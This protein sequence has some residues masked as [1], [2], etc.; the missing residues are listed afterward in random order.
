MPEENFLLGHGE[1][2]TEEITGSRGGG[3]KQPPYTFQEAK[4]RLS[5]MLQQ[6]VSHLYEL[7]DDAFPGGS[8]VLALTLNPEYIAKSYFP[9]TLLQ[10]VGID[11]VGSRPKR[12]I[13]EKRSRNRAPEETLTTELFA[14]G[15]RSLFRSWN[16]DL[17]NWSDQDYSAKELVSVEQIAAP[18]TRAKIKGSLPENGVIPMEIVLH[19]SEDEGESYMLEAFGRFLEA[20]AIGHDFGR[21]FY[22][23]GLCF[24]SMS[25]PSEHAE[26]IAAF[27]T[28]RALRKLPELRAFRPPMR[29]AG[30][31]C[32]LPALP[33]ENPVSSEVRVA[34]F[35][36]GIPDGHPITSW[37]NPCECGALK[38]PTSEFHEHGVAVTSA[39][40]FGHISPNKSI[41]RP[42]APIDHYRV[43]DGNPN[44]VFFELYEVLERI[45]GVLTSCD[46]DFV[47]L[48]VGPELPIDDD[49]VH[50]WT[51]VID[52]L[53]SRNST[54]A[55]IAVGNGGESDSAACLDRIQVPSDCVNALAVGACDSMENDW[56]RAPYSSVG[57]GR[58][59][60]IIKPDLVAFGGRVDQP[61]VVMNHEIAPNLVGLFGTSFAAPSIVRIAS[62]V[63]AHF[64]PI[65]NHLAIRALLIHT[66]EK[67]GLDLQE[68]GW[69]RC[70][71]ELSEI[72]LCAD[73]EIRV[74]YQGAIS[75]AKYIR[76]SIPMPPNSIKGTVTL[77][78]TFCYKSETDPHHP[79]N[80]TRAGLEV[81]FRPHSEKFKNENQFHP[82]SR[83]FFGF[84]PSG[85]NEVQLRRDA[86]K[87]ENCLSAS[88]RFRGTSLNNPVFDIHFNSRQEGRNNSSNMS[89]P[90]ALIVSV[91][92]P[93]MDDF[94]DQVV[95]K[96]ATI[97][98]PLQPVL[99]IP[100][101]I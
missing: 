86:F 100:L 28:V 64:G 80:Y 11:V 44:Q 20:R 71:Q 3:P 50:A 98:E 70:A 69:G 34:V 35:D 59:P 49:E 72:V 27:S 77:E 92:A 38:P 56:K 91:R 21:R 31:S 83:S 40:L 97:L 45:A 60:G 95:R 13:P 32:P 79:S 90:Y 85:A 14:R 75:P 24:L 26:E 94:Y 87:W 76:A 6:A 58:S 9:T 29:S 42:Y 25:V 52:Q 101:Q 37:A 18:A 55:A 78:A 10:K 17:P 23:N 19:A 73:D 54:L 93:K 15:H 7:P 5:P 16:A 43:I 99:D 62:G 4:V 65:L 84:S 8:A 89:L 51:A 33:N 53:L 36:G 66:V 41:A 96:Y 30:F 68:I 22:S 67:G 74:V 63:R 82:D 12:V 88:K 48:C 81:T 46:Y 2:L 1:R 61:Y 57:P 39:F 47:I